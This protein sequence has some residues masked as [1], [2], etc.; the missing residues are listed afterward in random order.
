M[1]RSRTGMIA[2]APRGQFL[3]DDQ[4]YD[5]A[6]SVFARGAHESRSKQY[7]H[8]PT[9]EI[10]Q[11]LYREGFRVSSVQQANSRIEGKRA[12][13]KHLLRLRYIGENDGL[14]QELDAQPEIC[15]LNSHDGTSAY[16]LYAGIIRFACTNGL[17]VADSSTTRGMSIHHKGNVA[18]D[19]INASYAILDESRKAMEQAQH[20]Q[21]IHLDR[22]EAEILAETVRDI[23]FPRV[24]GKEPVPAGLLLQPR[25]REDMGN[26]LWVVANKIQENA[27]RGGIQYWAK[28]PTA[29]LG[30]G[31]K[32]QTS[33]PVKA[34]D[35]TVNINR[36]I[37]SCA[38]TMAQRLDAYHIRKQA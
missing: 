10:L 9:A 16:R 36:H 1:F 38:E 15:L 24:E 7:A 6:P 29:F 14:S 3:T 12:F 13:T 28:K 33:R 26:S 32:R 21:E 35:A 23:R 19:V 27:I 2:A 20:W 34:I 22:Q 31:Y 4:I 30:S 25:R 5:L 17:I 8:I 18:E 11:K 37:W